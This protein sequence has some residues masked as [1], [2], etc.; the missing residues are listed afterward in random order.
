[1][2]KYDMSDCHRSQR[3]YSFFEARAR[4]NKVLYAATSEAEV[5]VSIRFSFVTLWATLHRISCS[6][7][8][9]GGS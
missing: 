8:M 9:P 5:L 1:M 3:Q 2:P 7:N 4:S 6:S